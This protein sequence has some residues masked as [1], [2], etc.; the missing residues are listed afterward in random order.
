MTRRS[1]LL[2]LLQKRPRILLCTGWQT[3][4]IGDV[5]FTPAMLTALRRYIPEADVT[6]WVKNANDDVRR[7]IRRDFP[8]FREVNGAIGD[9][10]VRQAFEEMDLFLY[11]SGMVINYGFVYQ[12]ATSWDAVMGALLPLYRAKELGKPY[13]IYAQTFDAFAE[14]SPMVVRRVL[15]EASFVYTRDTI[16]LDVLRGA[17][18]KP[19]AMDFAPDIALQYR[20]RDD[21]RAKAY[22]QSA[23]LEPG[24]FLMSIGHYAV[25][26][27]P[28]V[29]D[30]GPEHCARMRAV[31]ERWIRE[32]GL[33]V[34]LAPEDDREMALNKEALL[35]PLPAAVKAQVKLRQTFW[36]PDEALSVALASRTM[37]NMEPHLNLMALANGLPCLHCYDYAFGKKAQMFA[38]FGMGKW[39]FDL[40]KAS[41]AEMGDAL[42]AVH[43]DYAGAQRYRE[44]GM[45]QV[46][47]KTAAAFAVMRRTL[48][49]G[50]VRG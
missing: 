34:L 40:N 38:D 37:F 25:L 13:G 19:P 39:A 9:A 36:L 44:Q 12:Q 27:R 8:N 2:A 6:C 3:R 18:V 50:A 20:Q 49:L 21:A 48:G 28:S 32:T 42:L 33:P 24:K 16:S 26:T 45:K 22:L 7:M 41:A 31:I 1:L 14:P 15:S 30:R 29:K 47:A 4:N 46:E 11:N 43:Q 17:G 5:C 35:D 23:G 10:P